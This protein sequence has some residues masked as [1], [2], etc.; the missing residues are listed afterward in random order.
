MDSTFYLVVKSLH[1]ISMVAWMAG[2]LYLY[3]LF[4]Y[5]SMESETV[6]KAR[7]Q[8]M[9]YRLYR[10]ITIPA[11]VATYLFGIAMLAL[12]PDFFSQ[13]WFHMKLAAVAGMTWVTYYGGAQKDALEAGDCKTT[14]RMFRIL[15]EVPTL[16]LIVIVFM[17]VLK[18]FSQLPR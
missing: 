3:R 18:P 8:V 9:E 4:V 11:M 7:L 10:Y 14:T 6:V 16:L 15:N 13:G 17:V 12:K 5:H 1:I 2:V